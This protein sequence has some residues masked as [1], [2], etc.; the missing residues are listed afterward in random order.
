LNGKTQQSLAPIVPM[1]QR[2]GTQERSAMNS[3]AERRNYFSGLF[4]V[5]YLKRI[6]KH[7]IA[8]VISEVEKLSNNHH[9][10]L[11]ES[12]IVKMFIKNKKL[13]K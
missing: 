2:H 8:Q 9:Q 13:N 10:K 6:P 7:V 5:R 11:F 4:V 1:L 12:R 3:H